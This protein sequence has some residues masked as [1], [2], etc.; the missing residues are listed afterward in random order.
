MKEAARVRLRSLF[1]GLEPDLKHPPVF[2]WEDVCLFVELVIEL[3]RAS[4]GRVA[5]P[6]VIGAAKWG[7]LLGIA[8]LELKE[9]VEVDTVEEPTRDKQCKPRFMLSHPDRWMMRHQRPMMLE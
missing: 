8:P 6:S 7:I 4:V 9:A 3:M 5:D 2:A 1:S